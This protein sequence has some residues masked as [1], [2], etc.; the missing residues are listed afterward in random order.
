[1]STSNVKSLVGEVDFSFHVISSSN[2]TL[3]AKDGS[4]LSCLD[5]HR[6]LFTYQPATFPQDYA[7]YDFLQYVTELST[8]CQ[9]TFCNAT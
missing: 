5:Y 7:S 6:S 9:Y 2:D 1:M 4:K 3:A 8:S